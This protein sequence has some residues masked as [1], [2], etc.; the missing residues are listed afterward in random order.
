M[1]NNIDFGKGIIAPAID[2]SARVEAYI[3]SG[4]V[5]NHAS[6]ILPMPNGDLL[7]VWF[8]G[9]QEGMSDI[10]VY[11]SRLKLGETRWTD[12][13]K[14][15]GNPDRSEQNPMLF[16]LPGGD[17]WLLWTAQPSGHQDES[18][19][20]RRVSSDGGYT[21]GEEEVFIDRPGTFIRQPI[22]VTES[23]EW[24]LPVF[25][26]IPQEGKDWTGDLDYSA[27]LI[28]PDEGKSWTETG[29][30]ESTGC[31]HMNIVKISDGTLSAFFR[32][33]W[34]DNIYVSR[35]VDGGHSWTPAEP[36]G[37]PNNNSSIQATELKN[38]RL[39]LVFNNIN[40]D[41]CTER[42]TSL[43]DDI[44]DTSEGEIREETET[45]AGNPVPPSEGRSAFW[46]VPRAP[47][48][49][50]VSED[51]GRT[52]PYLR[53]LEVGDGY[54][55]TNSSKDGTN[56]EYSYPS[57]KQTPDGK[58]HITYTYFRQRIKY[59]CVDESWVTG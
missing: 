31:V 5:Q 52:W 34:A 15:S 17:T 59:V 7:C 49:L 36:A 14:L 51:G 56:R 13:E 12:S 30:P 54:C 2:D 27:V 47:L 35:S 18:L 10:S 9:T 21:W 46:G 39:A 4:N 1:E 40:G 58:L 11:C 3:P 25:Y 8:S 29:V 44:E 23:G 45:A 33:R 24:L 20:M 37:L 16:N 42:R 48:T 57:I 41:E 22:V 53:D 6:N 43:Y 32:S 26:C 28:S 50:A 55:M 38:G 19:V